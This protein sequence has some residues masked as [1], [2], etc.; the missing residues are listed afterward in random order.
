MRL[1]PALPGLIAALAL[2]VSADTLYDRL[3]GE[4]GVAAIAADTLDKT[5]SDPQTRRSFAKVNMK[6][7]KTLVAEQLCQ[8]S[9]GPCHYSGESM[10]QSHAGLH[11]TEAEFYRMVGH[12]RAVLD[13][14]QVAQADKNALLAL[15]APM[16]RDVVEAKP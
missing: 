7:L 3:G 12:L 10:K 16:K 2:P 15:L 9:G 11:I 14:R 13:T 4:A 6:R 8:I 5:A 1:I